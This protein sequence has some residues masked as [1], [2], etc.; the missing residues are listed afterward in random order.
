[1]S[2]EGTG[3]SA[4]TEAT[5]SLEHRGADIDRLGA[6]LQAL[7]TLMRASDPMQTE[8][9]VDLPILHGLGYLLEVMGERV[10]NHGGMVEAGAH[11]MR[12]LSKPVRVVPSAGSAQ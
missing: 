10:R 8:G 9:A 4:L 6:G 5:F 11:E 2:K 3:L 7:A 12:T 1:M